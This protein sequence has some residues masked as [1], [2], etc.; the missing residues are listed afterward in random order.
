MRST[1][2]SLS[3]VQTAVRGWHRHALVAMWPTAVAEVTPT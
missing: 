1:R 3:V 2:L